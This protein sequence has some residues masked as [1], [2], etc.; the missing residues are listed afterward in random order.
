MDEGK[1][2]LSPPPR[3]LL[4]AGA[5][6][7]SLPFAMSMSSSSTRTINGELVASTYRDWLAVGGGGVALA[8]GLAGLVLSLRAKAGGAWIAG[9]LAIAAFGGYQLA[10][11]FGVFEPHAESHSSVTIT[12]TRV[13]KPPA[14]PPAPVDPA[15]CP[16][17]NTCDNL[18]AELDKTD[19]PAALVARTRSCELGE[20][21]ACRDA[22]FAL[23]RA[24]QSAKAV[25]FYQKGCDLDDGECCYDLSVD[26]ATGDGVAKDPARSLALVTKSCDLQSKLA[27]KNLALLYDR[28][29]GVKADAAKAFALAV[30]ACDDGPGVDSGMAQYVG[31]ACTL[32]AKSLRAGKGTHKDA[33]AAAAYDASALVYYKAGC[34][35]DPAHC[36]NLGNAYGDGRGV[37]KDLAMAKQLYDKACQAGDKIGCDN[38]K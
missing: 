26:Y 24:N 20:K 4:V 34:D 9:A 25:P 36:V 18:A 32:A 12:E 3:G 16:D 29:E 6:A 38:L 30:K 14:P 8:C 11:G 19:K 10:R 5:V 28:G 21:Y 1:V 37:K 33:K 2:S 35:A 13:A 22:A 31:V 7:G 23:D 17:Q 27:C 15:K